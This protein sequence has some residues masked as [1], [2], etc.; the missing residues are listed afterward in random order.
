[1]CFNFV[2]DLLWTGAGEE[3]EQL[4][5]M[6]QIKSLLLTLIPSTKSPEVIP[7]AQKIESPVTLL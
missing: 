5:G 6:P 7:V 3:P 4:R 1:M 2:V